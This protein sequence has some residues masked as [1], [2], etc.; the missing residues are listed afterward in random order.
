MSSRCGCSQEEASALQ[1]RWLHHL[2]VQVAAELDR[3]AIGAEPQMATA[4]S[5]R[6][7]RIRRRLHEGPP[8][9]WVPPQVPGREGGLL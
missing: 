2:L 1:A 7:M 9:D 8:A 4:L 6:A 5:Q 3:L